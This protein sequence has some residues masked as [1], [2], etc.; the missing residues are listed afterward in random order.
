MNRCKRHLSVY[1][2]C[3]H[4]KRLIGVHCRWTHKTVNWCTIWTIIITL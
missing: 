4:A 2:E 3:E 1:R